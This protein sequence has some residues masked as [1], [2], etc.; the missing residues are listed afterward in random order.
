MERK[1]PEQRPIVVPIISSSIAARDELECVGHQRG[2]ACDSGRL[3]R[4]RRAR[5]FI[6]RVPTAQRGF[7]LAV[8]LDHREDWIIADLGKP[9]RGSSHYFR[10]KLQLNPSGHRLNFGFHCSAPVAQTAR[11]LGDESAPV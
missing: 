10:K 11:T 5:D 1:R 2:G 4:E 6:L 3:G 7:G 8:R 9:A